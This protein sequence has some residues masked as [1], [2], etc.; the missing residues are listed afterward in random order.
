MRMGR[1][2][3]WAAP[4]VKYL[5]PFHE[6]HRLF[7]VV[8]VTGCLVAVAHSKHGQGKRDIFFFS[9]SF[10]ADIGLWERR[11]Q[12][13]GEGARA[14]ANSTFPGTVRIQMYGLSSLQ[15]E[16]RSALLSRHSANRAVDY[17]VA[18]RASNGLGQACSRWITFTKSLSSRCLS[19][20]RHCD[21]RSARRAGH[22]PC[23]SR[24]PPS[25][26]PHAS[27]VPTSAARWCARA[28]AANAKMT[29]SSP[30][31][32]SAQ[33]PACAGTTARINQA[34][35]P[36]AAAPGLDSWDVLRGPAGPGF[37]LV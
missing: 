24:S 12:K 34:Q 6:F 2:K 29:A 25:R 31:G 28:P 22:P 7:E 27:P 18:G 13:K 15:P 11:G 9:V 17:V 1:K 23:L 5:V 26:R 33:S 36:P 35:P 3:S 20:S 10:C 16:N 37:A 8:F 32:R 21:C 19:R 4:S 30:S 14:Y